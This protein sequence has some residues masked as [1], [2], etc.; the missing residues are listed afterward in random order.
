VQEVCQGCGSFFIAGAGPQVG[1][2]VEQGPVEAHVTDDTMRTTS[3]H[4]ALVLIGD[5]LGALRDERLAALIGLCTCWEC[6]EQFRERTCEDDEP[7][8][9]DE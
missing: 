7:E 8:G 9:G 4:A 1:P 5:A 2:F 3:R 6:H